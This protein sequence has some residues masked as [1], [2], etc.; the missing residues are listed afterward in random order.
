MAFI[1]GFILGS[2]HIRV[3]ILKS[4]ISASLLDTWHSFILCRILLASI[5]NLGAC[6]CPRCMIPLACAH[7]VG[8]VRDK[9][10][11]ST[12]IRIDDDRRRHLV[13]VARR[14]IYEKSYLVTGAAVEGLLKPESL[15]PTS[16]SSSFL[17]CAYLDSCPPECI[18]GQTLHT[19]I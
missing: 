14:L 7:H 10:Q 11:R 4:T 2:S 1:D 15:V 13:A 5:R 9:V 12:L 17:R 19:R 3:T 8:L 16:V 6:P 18:F